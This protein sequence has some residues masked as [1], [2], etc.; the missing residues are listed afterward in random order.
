[1][2]L[3]KTLTLALL[4][5]PF[6]GLC[7]DKS[8][9][10][11]YFLGGSLKE[12]SPE[13]QASYKMPLSDLVAAP[14]IQLMYKNHDYAATSYTVSILSRDLAKVVGQ[15]KLQQGSLVESAAKMGYTLSS[16]DRVFI[17]D[18]NAFC[19]KCTEHKNITTKG[20]AILI[21]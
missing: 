3:V 10:L 15:L 2:N 12:A 18:L 8:D 11:V 9:E 5:L 6:C 13:E 21:E 1:M 14:Y 17:D 4:L 20:V 19:G 16:G 7:Q